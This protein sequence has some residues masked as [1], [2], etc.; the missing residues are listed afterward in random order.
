MV[1]ALDTLEKGDELI[2]TYI[3]G[4]RNFIRM[5]VAFFN[6]IEERLYNRRKQSHKKSLKASLKLQVTLSHLSTIKS[7]IHC[8]TS[9]GLAELPFVNLPPRCAKFYWQNFNRNISSVQQNHKTEEASSRKLETDGTSHILLVHWMVKILQSR[10]QVR[11]A[12]NILTTRVTSHWYWL[13]LVDAE[14]LWVN[15]GSRGS[16]SDAQIFK[17]SKLRRRRRRMPL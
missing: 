7:Y 17:C 2:T 10:S 3:P 12:V 16:S 5:P 11:Q 9:G 6:L 8:S 13:A 1:Y 14:Y 4:Y 15:V